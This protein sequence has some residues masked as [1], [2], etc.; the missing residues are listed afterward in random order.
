MGRRAD[1]ARRR[2][3]PTTRG[4]APPL[5]AERRLHG[6][7]MAAVAAFVR[8]NKLDR[9]EID[10][11]AARLGIVTTGKAY[12]GVRQALA[13]LRLDDQAAAALGIPL[14]KVALT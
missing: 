3:G 13:D 2:G 11:R 8:A 1:S 9:L 14:Y 6:P 10:P 4:P 5:D 7:K 12:L